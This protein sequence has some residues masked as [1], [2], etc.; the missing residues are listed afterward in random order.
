M[1]RPW[2]LGHAHDPPAPVRQRDILQSLPVD[3]CKECRATLVVEAEE[4]RRR[5]NA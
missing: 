2:V 1:K 4:P 3:S 5:L